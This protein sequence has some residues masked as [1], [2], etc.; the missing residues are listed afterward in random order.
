MVHKHFSNVWVAQQVRWDDDVF[1]DLCRI[2]KKKNKFEKISR[3][4]SQSD[5]SLVSW[6]KQKHCFT[7]HKSKCVQNLLRHRIN[8]LAAQFMITGKKIKKKN[9]IWSSLFL[10]IKV[11]EYCIQNSRLRNSEF[12]TVPRK[13]SPR[14]Q[15]DAI[16]RKWQHQDSKNPILWGTDW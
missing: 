16:L 2:G 7:W 3:L 6:W 12:G 4:Y 5:A 15:T 14:T 13:V 11:A 10:C 1:S 9:L 8:F